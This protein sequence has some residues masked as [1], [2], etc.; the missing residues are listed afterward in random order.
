[1]PGYCSAISWIFLCCDLVMGMQVNMF[2][3]QC[4]NE[5]GMET[6]EDLIDYV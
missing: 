2:D 6:L 5:I 1:M 4:E 3:L